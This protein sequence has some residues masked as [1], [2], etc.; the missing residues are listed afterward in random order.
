MTDDKLVER[1]AKVYYD[2][3]TKEGYEAAVKHAD[4]MFRGN[5]ELKD[6]VKV[7]VE[8]LLS[9]RGIRK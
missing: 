8:K 2:K 4:R 3:Y 5:P 6:E 9:K 1:I 7:A